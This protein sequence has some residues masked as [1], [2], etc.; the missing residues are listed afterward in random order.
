[1]RK[2]IINANIVLSNSI[3]HSGVCC[4]T[5]G[6]IDYVGT[7]ASVPADEIIDAHGGW[8]LPGFIDIHCHG[9]NGFD[10]MDATVDE[11]RQISEFHLKH[12]TTTLL[13]TTMTGTWS[14]IYSALDNI[15]ELIASGN[16]PSVHGV[17]ME[18][19]WFNPAQC[20]AQDT[21]CMDIPN[22]Q[23]LR[24][25]VVKYPFIE[26][27]SA[28]PELE[29]GLDFGRTGKELGL[30]VSA[31]HTDAD[32][33]Q[34][35]EAADNGYSLMTHLYSGM[36]LTERRNLYRVAG[37]VEAGIYDDRLYV[38]LICDGKHLPPELLKMVCKI[39]GTDKVCLIT[40][41]T[42]GAGLPNGTKTRIRKNASGGEIV[43][44]DGVAKL[45]D[46][47]A[48]AGSTATTERLLRVIHKDAGFDLIQASKMLS[49][50]PAKI[51]GYTDRGSIEVGNR[52]DLVM[53]DSD[54]NIKT[55]IWGG[56]H[57]AG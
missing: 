13:A 9:G 32:F 42:R 22:P 12:G 5:D 41:A 55:I 1:M 15:A 54:L 33:L 6:T 18:G 23:H 17:H 27:V 49:G 25:L 31:G 44:D 3:L 14:E 2:K 11:M 21:S 52:A 29:N 34:I 36:R 50:V 35:Q 37:A 28:A 7:D 51:M 40:D 53:L 46:M 26:R 57:Y 10:F 30:I 38:E 47:T 56:N 45:A 24:Q 19:P 39:K 20:G 8:L 16:A 4:Y 43:I 48:F